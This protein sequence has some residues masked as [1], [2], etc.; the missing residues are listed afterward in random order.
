MRIFFFNS[1]LLHC[2]P[3]KVANNSDLRAIQDL[4]SIVLALIISAFNQTTNF[5]KRLLYTANSKSINS[6]IKNNQSSMRKF[7]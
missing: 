4:C 5:R 2:V 3:R 6:G 1:L 7:L